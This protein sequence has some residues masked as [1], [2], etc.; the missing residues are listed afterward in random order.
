ADPYRGEIEGGT[1][2][3]AYKLFLSSNQ[4]MVVR[5]R[6]RGVLRSGLRSRDL[7]CERRSEIGRRPIRDSERGHHRRINRPLHNHLGGQKDLTSRCNQPLTAPMPRVN[8][9]KT[10]PL[11]ATLVLASEIGRA[12]CR[13]ECRSRG[14]QCH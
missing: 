14:W 1:G 2:W 4:P 3:A 9:M 12:S 11:Q 5:D 13:K 6:N 10:P 7:P 8:F